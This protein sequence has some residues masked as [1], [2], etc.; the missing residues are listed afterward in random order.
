MAVKYITMITIPITLV[1]ILLAAPLSRLLYGANDYPYVPLFLSIFILNYAWEGLGGMSLSSL[2]SGIGESRVN[3]V[4]NALTFVAGIF[5]VYILVPSY[6]MV[7]LLV[8]IIL[9]SRVGWIYQTLW[10]KKKL[11][12][13][14]DWLSSF[15]IYAVALIAF[16]T[17]DFIIN[18]FTLQ[19]WVRLVVG[20]V[21]YFFVYLIGLPLVGVLRRGDIKQINSIIDVLGPLAPFV[22]LITGLLDRMVR[23]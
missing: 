20:T 11:G 12:I 23:G 10:A 16:V 18:S 15:K 17:A 4:A 7:G 2:I 22:K 3:L 21:G 13:T 19:G 5:M 6:Q 14:I 8:V 9:D 1:I